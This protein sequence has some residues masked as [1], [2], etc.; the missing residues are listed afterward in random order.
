MRQ[1]H[2]KAFSALESQRG[3]GLTSE[4][5]GT[6]IREGMHHSQCKKHKQNSGV[7]ACTSAK[8]E[9]GE[10]QQEMGKGG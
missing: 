8:Q 6:A 1:V 4:N 2:S 10:A 5:T 7:G 3:Q 9:E